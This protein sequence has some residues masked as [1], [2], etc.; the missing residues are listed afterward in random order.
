MG[1]TINN[2]GTKKER[3]RR[4][5]GSGVWVWV[6]GVWSVV[7][8][9]ERRAESGEEWDWTLTRDCDCG[10]CGAF[11][12]LCFCVGLLAVTAMRSNDSEQPTNMAEIALQMFLKQ[13]NV[14]L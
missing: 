5:S 4:P 8:S 2:N 7:E 6:C 9:G 13:L 10:P 1:S 11:P 14:Y 3:T 12:P